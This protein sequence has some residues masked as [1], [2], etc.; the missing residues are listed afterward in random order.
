MTWLRTSHLAAVSL[1][2][3][4]PAACIA[5]TPSATSQNQLLTKAQTGDSDAQYQLG[6]LYERGSTDTPKN[7]S[8]AIE[9]FRRSAERGNPKGENALGIAYAHGYGVVEDEVVGFNWFYKA[10]LKGYPAAQHNL[11]GDYRSGR[12]T[13]K[14]ESAAFDWSLKSALN[15]EASS[16]LMLC[17]IYQKSTSGELDP[18][19]AYAWCL[20]AQA[21]APKQLDSHKTYTDKQLELLKTYTDRLRVSLSPVQ[22]QEATLLAATWERGSFLG[23]YYAEAFRILT[24]L[25]CS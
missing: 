3:F 11:A 6:L 23:S 19:M 15:G 20:I 14:N 10:A 2:L 1:G 17:A 21:S 7:Y 9:W 22:L 25:K 24:R 12:G 18:T 13:P 4:F 8:K 16:Q 5:Q